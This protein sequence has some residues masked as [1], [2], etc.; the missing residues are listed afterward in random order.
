ML[1]PPP[2]GLPTDPSCSS[3]SVPE[4]DAAELG[5]GAAVELDDPLRPEPVDPRLLQPRRARLG[6]VP[7]ELQAGQVVGVAHLLR[8][9]PDPPHHR[10]HEVDD[11]GPVVLDRPQRAPPRRTASNSTTCAPLSTDGHDQ[12]SGPLWY[13]GPGITRQP[14]GG[15]P[16]V[17]DRG[18]ASGS[19]SAASRG[20][21][22]LRPAGGPARRRRLPR[23]AD[24]VGQRAPVV[25]ASAGSTVT[26]V[27]EAGR[28]RSVI[29]TLDSARSTHRGDLRV[30]HLHVQR[31]R[32]GPDLPDGLAGDE[33]VRAVAR[34]D[35]HQVADPDAVLEQHAGQ[36]VGPVLELRPGH[37]GRPDGDG[38]PVGVLLPRGLAEALDERDHASRPAR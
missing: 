2:S 31:L 37:G 28:R 5:L 26:P 29:T 11:V 20:H 4:D 33:P 15:I 17:A 24:H 3:H 38:G 30:G 18:R 10:R 21:D 25:E 7:D 32:D 36:R 9:P 34:H 23:R 12:I 19:S 8:E 35:R 27:R 22:E 16:N 14:P 1:I 13:S 6:E